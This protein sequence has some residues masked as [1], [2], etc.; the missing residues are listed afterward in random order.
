[1]TRLK[2]LF[3]FSR[4]MPVSFLRVKSPISSQHCKNLACYKSGGCQTDIGSAVGTVAA[5]VLAG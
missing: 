4:M 1:L 3:F 2:K 5:L